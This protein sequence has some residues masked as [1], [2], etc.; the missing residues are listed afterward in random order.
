LLWVDA[1]RSIIHAADFP[2]TWQSTATRSWDL[3]RHLDATGRARWVTTAI[4]RTGG[5]LVATLGEL[6]V[7][8]DDDDIE[9]LASLEGLGLA[10][11]VRFNDAKV[12]PHGRLVAGWVGSSD[13]AGGVVRF[14][15]A[16]RLEVVVED[17]GAANGLDWSPDGSTF[18][19]ADTA[20]GTV[21]AFDDPGDGPMRN[22]R[23]LV[24]FPAG[25]PPDGLCTDVEGGL[26]V[27]L[28][29]RGQVQRFSPDGELLEVLEIPCPMPTSAAFGGPDGRTLFITSQAIPDGSPGRDP[30][31]DALLEQARAHPGATRS[32]ELFRCEPGVAGFAARPFAGSPPALIDSTS[33]R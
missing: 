10:G 23:V 12:D 21:S 18:Y 7:A 33:I 30:K 17:V 26:W 32:G 31:L 25:H 28:P 16:G 3:S 15:G 29:F 22:R 4:P 20:A 27:A 9:T 24:D 13:P 1:A 8:V 11:R 2:S 6:V 14:D 19:L 5:G